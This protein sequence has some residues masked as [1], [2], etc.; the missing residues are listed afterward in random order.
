MNAN[1]VNQLIPYVIKE[2]Q[3]RD[4]KATKTKILKILYLFDVSYYRKH[5]ETFT[6]F[7]WVFLHF[8]PWTSE[9]DAIL[10]EL[11]T[12][13]IINR[14]ESNDYNAEFLSVTDKIE[15][16]DEF[17][18][19]SAAY[20]AL[21]SVL[22]NWAHLPLDPLLNYVYF[23]TEPMLNGVRYEPL[24][25]STISHEAPARYK[26]PKSN[27]PLKRLNELKLQAATVF[28]AMRTEREASRTVPVEY[29]EVWIRGME[30][31]D[32]LD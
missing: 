30:A 21:S 3:R 9:Y 1:K 13:N 15:H 29:G 2:V 4:G 8:G 11:A 18:E 16:S 17:L 23:H 32:K 6:G 26:R 22:A 5:R 28:A 25:F 7:D 19:G 20:L 14:A 10:D 27:T 31:L 12:D 24:D